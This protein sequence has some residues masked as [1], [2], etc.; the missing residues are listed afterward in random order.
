MPMWTKRWNDAVE[1]D[2]GARI[3]VCRYRP[4]GVPRE[5]E[6]W[7]AWMPE[8]GPSKEL[9]ADA[10]G[11][12]GRPIDWEQYAARYLAEM[13]RPQ[14]WLRGLRDRLR[15]GETLTLLCSSACVDAARC[16]RTLLKTLLEQSL[17]VPSPSPT[18]VRR[19]KDARGG[20]N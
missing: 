3:L 8:L 6:P 17:V 12:H 7:D 19:A 20:S 11:K 1:P 2:D 14:F 18:V 5:G 13:Q 10:Y 4:R 15:T 16:H 9:H